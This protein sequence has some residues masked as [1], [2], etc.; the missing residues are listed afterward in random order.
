MKPLARY[1]ALNGYNDL[2]RSLGIDPRDLMRRCGLDPA[3]LAMP[4]R[5]V[6][7]VAV[8]GL[9]EE[10]ARQSGREDFGLRLA[11]LRRFSNLGP[12]SLVIREEPD[13]R[14][15]LRI[16]G[17]YEHMYNESL[18]TRLTESSGTATIR[19]DLDFGEPAESRQAIELAAAVLHRLLRGFLG[20]E[21]RPLAVCFAHHPPADTATH[22]R[23]FGTTVTFDHEFHGL[24]FSAADLAAPNRMADPGLHQY[25]YHLLE[26]VEPSRVGTVPDRV[27]ELIEVLLP[28]GRCS[29]E[30]V[31]RSLGVNRRTVHRQLAAHGLTYSSVLDETRTALVERMLAGGHYTLTE[32]SELL[33]FSA[34]SNFTRWFRDRYGSSPSRWRADRQ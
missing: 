23:V 16:L 32:I 12:V 2:S 20:E 33:S 11:E 7:A 13:V 5:W 15:M 19:V 8:A 9:L 27:R 4:D 34:P 28:T 18:R 24:V 17:R 31:A 10:S 22:R 1:A 14:S 29:I 3:G 21:W 30:Q 6:P 26:S 25:A